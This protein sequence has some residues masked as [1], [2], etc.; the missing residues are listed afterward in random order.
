[1]IKNCTLLLT[2]YD[3]GEDLWD[4]FFTCLTNE[5]PEFDLPIVLNTETKKY[6]FKNLKITTYG[7][8]KKKSMPWGK[9]LKE[10]LK[11]INTDFV[12]FF[13]DDF[14]LDEKVNNKEFEKVFNFINKNEDVAVVYFYPT[15][16]PNIKD[17]KL[18]NFELRPKKIDYKLTTSAA[19]WRREK[20]L[21]YIKDFENAWEWERNGSIRAS[22]Y[23]ER[24]YSLIEGSNK[25]ISY[26]N[27]EKGC[28]VHRGKWNKET[29]ESFNEK[30]KLNIDTSIRGFEDWDKIEKINKMSI[31][32]KI[33][34][35]AK[36]KM[37]LKKIYSNIVCLIQR[38]RSIL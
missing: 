26:A 3:G 14:W 5:W 10:N 34:Y 16:G 25:I 4:G 32:E 15:P 13:L 17:N 22:R 21:S 1:M 30:Y 6:S 11:L 8:C 33:V 2:S 38:L 20:L 7:V 18:E 37:L 31:N 9:R 36:H 23:K 24:F 29:I 12:L 19:I 35:Y 28:L 27:V